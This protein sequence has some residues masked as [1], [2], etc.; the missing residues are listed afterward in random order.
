MIWFFSSLKDENEHTKNPKPWID[1]QI[2][3]LKIKKTKTSIV[4]NKKDCQLKKQ[5]ILYS[6]TRN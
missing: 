5:Y 4:E 3:K 1:V 2:I 6:V